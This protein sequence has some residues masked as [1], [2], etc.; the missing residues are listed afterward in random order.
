M[1]A[2]ESPISPSKSGLPHFYNHVMQPD[3]SPTLF[4]E[5]I[6]FPKLVPNT[7]T[8]ETTL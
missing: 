2:P 3:A 6:A 7:K 1:K 4:Q 5:R 8:K